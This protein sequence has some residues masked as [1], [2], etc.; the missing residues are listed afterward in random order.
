MALSVPYTTGY[1]TDD[2]KR[3]LVNRIN[4]AA[5]HLHAIRKM[6]EEERCADDVLIQ[7]AAARSAVGQISAK[8]SRSTLPTA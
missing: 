5:G 7:L 6:I 3:R 1:L 4:R 8:I 2:T